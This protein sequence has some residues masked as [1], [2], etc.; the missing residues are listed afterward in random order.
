MTLR[1]HVLGTGERLHLRA[2][3][4]LDTFDAVVVA[5]LTVSDVREAVAWLQ[6]AFGFTERLRIGE[7]HRSQLEVPGGGAVILAEVRPDTRVPGDE[8][9]HSV[10]V[11]CGGRRFPFQR[12]RG[13][14]ARIAMEPTDFE[15]RRAPV[16]GR[17]SLRPPLDVL[18]DAV[19]RGSGRLAPAVSGQEPRL[20]CRCDRARRR[21]P[22]PERTSRTLG[23]LNP[24]GTRWPLDSASSCPASNSEE[25]DRVDAAIDVR[26]N[27]PDGLIFSASGPVEDGWRVIDVWESRAHFDTFAAERIGPAVAATGVSVQPDIAEF[28]VHEYVARQRLRQGVAA[29]PAAPAGRDVLGAATPSRY[30]R[31]VIEPGQEAPGFSLP[32]QGRPRGQA[33]GLPRGA[34]GRLLLPKGR[35][36]GLHDPSLWRARPQARL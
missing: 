18:P 13:A 34:R 19:R 1:D 21:P 12:A 11:Q 17:G 35:H 6:R 8:T 4:S 9:S 3:E 15:Y 30:A 28:P 2:C 5:V 7:G 14:G 27:H 36:A 32:D 16:R 29:G 20:P 23:R 26:G 33:V 10:M 31:A 22:R 25:F 24:R